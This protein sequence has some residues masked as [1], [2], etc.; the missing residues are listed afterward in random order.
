MFKVQHVLDCNFRSIKLHANC[1]HI[2]GKRG[3][4]GKTFLLVYLFSVG[5]SDMRRLLPHALMG[6]QLAVFSPQNS[7]GK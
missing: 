6:G 3:K 7:S 2:N 4:N 5:F 1:F